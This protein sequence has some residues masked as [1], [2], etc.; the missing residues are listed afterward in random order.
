MMRISYDQEV[1]ALVSRSQTEFGN[2]FTLCSATQNAECLAQDL[3]TRTNGTH[4]LIN[5]YKSISYEKSD[6]IKVML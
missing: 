2:A 1:D 4:F 5:Q 3:G 6:P